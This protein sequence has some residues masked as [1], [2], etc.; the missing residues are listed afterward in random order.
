MSNVSLVSYSVLDKAR[1]VRGA[2]P[3]GGRGSKDIR[4]EFWSRDHYRHLMR[5]AIDSLSSRTFRRLTS[6]LVLGLF[7]TLLRSPVRLV[8]LWSPLSSSAPPSSS[9]W[10]LAY[11]L[12]SLH[13]FSCNSC[14]HRL[15]SAPC[16]GKVLAEN[17]GIQPLTRFHEL[18]RPG[19]KA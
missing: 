16:F 14:S 9:T 2:C 1:D 11:S 8:V 18:S 3:L 13:S 19:W 7:F 12:S 5:L 4:L 15:W 17:P 10:C 6:A